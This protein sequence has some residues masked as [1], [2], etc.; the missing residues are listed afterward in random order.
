MT[1][2]VEP[3]TCDM[4][5]VTHEPCLSTPMHMD[6]TIDSTVRHLLFISMIQASLQAAWLHARCLLPT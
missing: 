4:K 1:L 5:A 3:L 6:T 2:G